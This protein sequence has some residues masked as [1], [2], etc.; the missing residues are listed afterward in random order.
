MNEISG[1]I[2]SINSDH[3]LSELTVKTEIGNFFIVLLETPKTAD[4]LKIGKSVNLLFK[5][6]EVEIFKNC[7]FLEKRFLNLFS[8]SIVSINRGKV[9]SKISIKSG[10]YQFESIILDRSVDMQELKVNDN[11]SFHI[12]PNEITVEVD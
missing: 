2:Y 8:G 5:E 6:T 10:N 9:L 4:Y 11:I 1:E 12:K 7:S 3:L